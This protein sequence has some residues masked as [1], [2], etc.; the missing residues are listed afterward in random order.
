MDMPPTDAY[1]PPP[2]SLGGWR[3]LI[4]D[5]EVRELSGMD[6]GRLSLISREQELLVGGSS[7]AIV[8]IRRGY[9]VREFRSFNVSATTRF[10]VWSCTKSFTGTAWGLLLDDSRRGTL[11]G[12]RSID[13]DTPAYQCIP[14]GHPLSDPRKEQITLG[15]LLT[16]TSGIPGERFSIYGSAAATGFGSFE[17]ALGRCPNQYGAWAA[18]LQAEPGTVFDYSD[19]AFS[20]LTLGFVHLTGRELAD[21]MNERVSGPIGIE[22]LDWGIQGG[23]GFIGPHSNPHSGIVVSA[24][25]LARFGYLMLHGGNWAGEQVVP[26]WWAQL[27]IRP[28][29]DANPTYGYT[30]WLNTNGTLWPGLPTDAFAAIGYRSCRCYVIPSLDLVV[31]RVGT[32][33]SVWEEPLLIGATVDSIVSD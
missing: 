8:I 20:H 3:Y 6:P 31:A 17:F 21:F 30:W 19:A 29:Q 10:D 13:L 25:E 22:K 14:E 16:M 7:Y 26:K 32:G 4:G 11:P 2:E 9:L 33:P 23:G 1:F 12:G 5:D 15:H 18:Q 28:S 27:A 24:R